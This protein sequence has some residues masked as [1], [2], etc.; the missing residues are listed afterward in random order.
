MGGQAFFDQLNKCLI[1]A[2]I[3]C[4][5][6]RKAVE[7][8]IVWLRMAHANAI[9]RHTHTYVYLYTAQYIIYSADP[10]ND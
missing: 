6:E 9:H 8:G 3:K 5:E 10:K 1:T 4:T 2:L 7:E